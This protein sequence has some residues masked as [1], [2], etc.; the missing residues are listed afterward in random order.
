MTLDEWI[1]HYEEVSASIDSDD[2]FGVMIAQ[3]WAHL[4]QKMPDGSKVPYTCTCLTCV[5]VCMHGR[6]RT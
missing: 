1:R 5:H 6:G 4:K 2:Y 3:T